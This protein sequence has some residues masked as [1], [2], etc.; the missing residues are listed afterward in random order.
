MV[1][2]KV[3]AFLVNTT[4]G[5]FGL[6]WFESTPLTFALMKYKI[7]TERHLVSYSMYMYTTVWH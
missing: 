6:G 7:E 2:N 4:V 1:D 3:L 5:S